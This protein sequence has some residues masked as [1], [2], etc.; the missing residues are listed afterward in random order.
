M[1]TAGP[2][3]PT[4]RLSPRSLARARGIRTSSGLGTALSVVAPATF[5]SCEGIKLP[6]ARPLGG[7]HASSGSTMQSMASI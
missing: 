2:N 5:G 3:A 6:A 7:E 4:H 1:K